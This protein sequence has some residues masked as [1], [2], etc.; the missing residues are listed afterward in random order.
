MYSRCLVCRAPFPET[1]VLGNLPRGDRVAYDPHRGRLWQV[2]RACRRWSLVPLESRW[3]ALEELERMVSGKGRLQSRTEHI[4]LFRVDALEIVRIGSAD[5]AEEAW[6]RFGQQ[7]PDPSRLSRWALPLFRRIR[8]GVM[9]WVGQKE[10]QVCGYVFRSLPLSDGK[11]LIVRPGEDFE[12]GGSVSLSRR[13]PGCKE[14]QDGGLG[15]SG[16][17]A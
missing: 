2:C 6:W 9:A 4:A 15:L 3:E 1:G 13:C 14:A 10:C 16:V 7:I 8:F 17:E 11:I 12:E 5:L